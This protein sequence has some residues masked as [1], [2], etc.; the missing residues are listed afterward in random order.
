MGIDLCGIVDKLLKADV[1][2]SKRTLTVGI[3]PLTIRDLPV[4]WIIAENKHP[5]LVT[6][7]V[8]SEPTSTRATCLSAA[9]G[10]SRA[11]VVRTTARSRKAGSVQTIRISAWAARWVLPTTEP[12]RPHRHAWRRAPHPQPRSPRRWRPVASPA[13]SRNPAPTA[14]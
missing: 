14:R 11:M 6:E 12:M 2:W 5:Q 3:G 4:G 9:S 1:D 7:L 13:Q 8:G 10:L